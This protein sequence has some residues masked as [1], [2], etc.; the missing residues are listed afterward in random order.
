MSSYIG[1]QLHQQMKDKT[2]NHS[3]REVGLVM[4]RQADLLTEDQRFDELV[5]MRRDVMA[6]RPRN[7]EEL[8]Q[9]VKALYKINIPVTST[10]PDY[11]SPFEYFA[12]I[13]FSRDEDAVALAAR[14]GGKALD[15]TTPIPTP[16]GWT[17]M[18]DLFE[19]DLVYGRDGK[20]CTVKFTTEIMYDHPCYRITFDDGTSLIADED[21]QWLVHTKSVREALRRR[22]KL[23]TTKQKLR[24]RRKGVINGPMV[25]TTKQIKETLWY[26]PVRVGRHHNKTQEANHAVILTCAVE[27]TVKELP[28]DPYLLGLWLGDGCKYH[29]Q[30]STVDQ[31]IVDA[32]TNHN[33]NIERIP[34]SIC[35]FRITKGFRTLLRNA[36]LLQN[37]HI[38]DIYFEGSVN[39][40]LA[41][42]QG[43]MDS[44]GT[45]ASSGKC[46][47]DNGNYALVT[48]LKTLLESLGVKVNI[49]SRIP[50]LNGK[51]C[52]VSYRLW[53]T[54]DS[55]VPFRLERKRIRLLP[56]RDT[57]HY[58]YIKSVEAV[59]SVPVKCIQVDSPDHTYLAGENF[60][61]THNT[62]LTSI[63]ADSSARFFPKLDIVHAGGTQVQAQ[64]A[65]G[66]LEEFHGQPPLDEGFMGK[67]AAFTAR[68]RN[69]SKWKIVTGSM[70]GVSGQHP[71]ILTLDEIEFWDI[72]AITQTFE[73]P[74][75]KNG[76]KRRWLA[77]STR[78]RSYGAMNWLVDEAPK[79]GF[80]FYQWTAFEM[81][82]PCRTCV[83]LDQ[84]PHG[85]DDARSKACILWKACKG[86]RARKASGW[87][88]LK[89]A[90]QKCIRLG[91]PDGREWQTQGL[92]QRPSSHGL[93]LHNFEK[94][95]GPGGNYS[96]W[97][98]IKE[99][100][101]YAVHDPAEGKKSVILF[102]QDYEG[103]S[104]IFDELVDQQ[105][106]DVTQAKKDFW[107]HCE[108]MGYSEPDIVVVDPHRTDAVATWKQGS[109][110]GVGILK[111]YNADTPDISEKG[112]GQLL[113]D[114]L[115][116]TRR[117]ICDG[118]YVRRIFI[119]PDYC[120]FLDRAIS[121][122]HYPTDNVTNEITSETP[123]KAYSDEI[124]PVRYWVMY[125][126]TKFREGRARLAVLS[127]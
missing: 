51:E 109:K 98:Y 74:V 127:G 6:H 26:G 89:E 7:S 60:I 35:D 8:H 50:K 125:K 118:N 119:N 94:V 39:Q 85:N 117:H 83:A 55:I 110:S 3:V 116:L 9:M 115:E 82:R 10:H 107:E 99:L 43:L 96:R 12:K 65:S 40:R 25:L 97:T 48:G 101:W 32:F 14:G 72:E 2:A 41:L 76:Y 111:K 113:R 104:Y 58:R 105:C 122:Y 42:V 27:K 38:P 75:N 102:V 87:L 84:E 57:Q 11:N 36:G 34:N 114:T 5:N 24:T 100:P 21:H 62:L 95:Y 64:V 124:D 90:Q 81:M 30:I 18:N 46:S 92:C 67:P 63:F 22:R 33:Y 23:E 16:T 56:V 66:Y 1:D 20:P 29:A 45:V 73:V 19:G 93:V 108:R 52:T 44:D 120:P 47:F 13:W 121:E 4:A 49:G 70:K 37:K 123:D 71:A 59:D 54:T 15:I 28:I 126:E 106:A 69:R 78:Q 79:R 77:F 80:R 91:G 88:S 86:E 53:F 61:V 68:Y 112:T 17:T 103:K 31:E